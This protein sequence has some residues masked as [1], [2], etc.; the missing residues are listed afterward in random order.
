[1]ELLILRHAPAWDREEFARKGK[2]DSS[3]PLTKEGIRKMRAAAAGLRAVSPRPA[4]IVSSPLVRARQTADIAARAF[5][6][7]RVIRRAEFAPEAPP[8][9]AA[10][11]LRARR[12]KVLA[13]VG[14]EPHLSLLIAHLCAGDDA[15]PFTALKKGGACLLEWTE[16]AATILW[17]LQPR[18]LRELG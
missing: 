3:R 13:V 12:E 17:L 14:H 2:P 10:A 18:E 5:G 1:M 4:L 6:D 9:S 8:D 15:R 11:W 7:I 16:R